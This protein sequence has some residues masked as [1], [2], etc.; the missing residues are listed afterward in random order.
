MSDQ[1]RRGV[2]MTD[3]YNQTYDAGEVAE[4]T[5]DT[6]IGIGAESESH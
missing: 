1:N 6:L 3:G 5:I 4:V 2:F